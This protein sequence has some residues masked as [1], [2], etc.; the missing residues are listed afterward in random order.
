M[1]DINDRFNVHN[2]INYYNFR[3]IKDNIYEVD[4]KGNYFMLVTLKTVHPN[5]REFC[6]YDIAETLDKQYVLVDYHTYVEY[7]QHI[8]VF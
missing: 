4:G 3:H 8:I 6:S 2:T 7:E 1:I 5:D